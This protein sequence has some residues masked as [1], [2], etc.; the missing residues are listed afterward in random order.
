MDE[1]LR[2]SEFE[3]ILLLVVTRLGGDAHGVLIRQALKEVAR[4]TATTGAIYTALDRLEQRGMV[5]ARPGEPSAERGGRA[6][7]YYR[8]E[9]PGTQALEEAEA[10]RARLRTRLRP[11]WEPA[12]EIDGRAS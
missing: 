1:S 3:E 11:G 12:G 9:A 5:S 7:N 6:K 2:L 10:M 4:R 8:I